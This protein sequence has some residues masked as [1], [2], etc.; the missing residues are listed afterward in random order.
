MDVST[1]SSFTDAC[2]K[3]PLERFRFR[4][5][6][7]IADCNLHWII[8]WTPMRGNCDLLVIYAVKY[9][10]SSSENRHAMRCCNWIKGSW[11]LFFEEDNDESDDSWKCLR[12]AYLRSLGPTMQVHFFIGMPSFIKNQN[13]VRQ[14]NNNICS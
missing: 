10:V 4:N 8:P 11:S 7:L 3:R 5:I 14:Y 6:V 12:T 2:Q 1:T 9:P 13:Q